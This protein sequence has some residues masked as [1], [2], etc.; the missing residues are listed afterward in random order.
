ME[1]IL[2]E[3]ELRLQ[4]RGGGLEHRA[5]SKIFFWNE[6][7]R[8]LR[9]KWQPSSFHFERTEGEERKSVWG[10][11][12][13]LRAHSTTTPDPKGGKA[14]WAGV[15]IFFLSGI[16]DPRRYFWILCRAADWEVASPVIEGRYFRNVGLGPLAGQGLDGRREEAGSTIVGKGRSTDY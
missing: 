6:A 10:K 8:W 3:E 15:P 13:V 7:K 11:L 2:R 9:L 12:S 4:H 1:T 5:A 14:C 16:I